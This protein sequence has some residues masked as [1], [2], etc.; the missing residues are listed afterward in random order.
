MRLIIIEPT[1]LC[2]AQGPTVHL[3]IQVSG[4]ECP[5]THEMIDNDP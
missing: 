1:I 4:I 5:I 3:G 2:G